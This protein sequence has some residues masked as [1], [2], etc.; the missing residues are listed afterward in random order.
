MNEVFFSTII[1]KARETVRE[2]WYK[3]STIQH[4]G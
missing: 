3:Q 4:Y 2:F 1:E